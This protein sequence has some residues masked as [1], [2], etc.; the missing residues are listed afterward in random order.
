MEIFKLQ[1]LVFNKTIAI[2]W[3][4]WREMFFSNM[5]ASVKLKSKNQE[6]KIAINLTLMG[7]KTVEIYNTFAERKER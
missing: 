7:E 6:I 5:K 3:P 2:K 1:S 4:K